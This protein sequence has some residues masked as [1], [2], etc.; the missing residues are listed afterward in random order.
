MTKRSSVEKCTFCGKSRHMVESLIA[1]PPHI[2]ICNECVELCNS[3]LAEESRRGRE[4][5]DTDL[6]GAREDLLT[7]RQINGLLDDYVISQDRAK[8]VIS[9]AVHNHFKRLLSDVDTTDVELEKSNILLLG[10]TGCGKTLIAKT[11]ARILDVPFAI[12]DATTL[13]EAGYVGED[14]E[15]LLLK[16]LQSADWDR[17]R[18]ER[19]IIFIDE[20]DKIGRTTMNVSIT[21]D[22]SGEGVQQALLKMLE[23]TVANVPPQGGRKH[24]EQSY[25]QIDTT[26]ILFICGGTFS[27]IESLIQRRIGQKAIGF[28]RG[29]ESAEDLG[30]I[31]DHAEPRDLLE[32]GLIP[33]FVGRLPIVAALHPL[34]E[35]DLVEIMT[36]PKNAILRQ[37]A[38]IF[39]L[40]DAE[41]T[42]TDEALLEVARMALSKET[43]VR[44]VRAILENVLL[45]I[46]YE[47]PEEGSRKEFELTPEV[48]R[49][50]ASL[51]SFPE[52]KGPKRE[53]A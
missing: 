34:T 11:L 29:P 2:Y 20:I 1:G 25:I 43:G 15:N 16:L 50:E 19:G 33:E 4:T 41:L 35:T 21:R 45:D 31:L 12:G 42:W 24:P 52:K 47:L 18:A 48:I 6:L 9:V 10:P 37:F 22:V 26:N 28:E 13:T 49:G 53:S 36:K 32:F 38:K 8:R 3:I 5:V 40:E 44:A 27:G 17:D 51:L 30:I 23:G 39:E 46:L 7:P 14:V